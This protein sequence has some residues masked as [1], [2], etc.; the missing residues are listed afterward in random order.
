M[1]D[2]FAREITRR[3]FITKVGQGVMAA[4]FAGPLLK[5][6]RGGSS[7]NQQVAL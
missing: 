5:G 7:G 2:S 6:A 3:G 1:S 4:N